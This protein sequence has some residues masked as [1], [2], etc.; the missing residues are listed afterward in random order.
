M[1]K[2]IFDGKH[3]DEYCPYTLYRSGCDLHKEYLKSGTS[4]PGLFWR[5]PKCIEEFGTG[6]GDE[7]YMDR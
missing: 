2:P 1:K 5:S 6:G 7:K 4:V 3:C